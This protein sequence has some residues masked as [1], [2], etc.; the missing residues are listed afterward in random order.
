MAKSIEGFRA[1][2]YEWLGFDMDHALVRY[3]VPPLSKL[4]FESLIE[5]ITDQSEAGAFPDLPYIRGDELRLAEYDESF[6]P[7]GVFLDLSTG[8]N[9]VA[10]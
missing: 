6:A 10:A 7:K 3:N 2:D 5:F 1:A 4:I 9:P 8:V